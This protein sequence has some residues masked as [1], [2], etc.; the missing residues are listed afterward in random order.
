[1][2]KNRRRRTFSQ[3]KF[4]IEEASTSYVFSIAA[5]KIYSLMFL[6]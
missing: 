4:V 1:M 6:R 2:K 5:N 3:K